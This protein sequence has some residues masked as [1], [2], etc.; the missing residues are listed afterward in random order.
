MK[1]AHTLITFIGTGR[2]EIARYCDPDESDAVHQTEYMCQ[3]LAKLADVDH[4]VLLGTE[5]AFCKHLSAINRALGEIGKPD[6]T[7]VKIPS[8][9]TAE[10]AWKIFTIVWRQLSAVAEQ[11][12]ILDITHGFRSQGF[13]AGAVAAFFR[14][15]NPEKKQPRLV[16]GGFEM[17]EG[18]GRRGSIQPAPI[19]DLT[20]FIDFVAWAEAILLF[21][22]TGRAGP[23]A[24]LAAAPAETL[25]F[26]KE[27]AALRD[28]LARLGCALHA[29][30]PDFETIRTGALLRGD[31]ATAPRL[32]QAVEVA[33]SAAQGREELLE[34]LI[35]ALGRVRDFVTPLVDPTPTAPTTLAGPQARQVL[36]GLARAY[37]RTGRY[38]EALT[39]VREG[40]VSL[41]AADAAGKPGAEFDR[42]ERG[43]AEDRLSL[44]IRR[45]TGGDTAE[46][47]MLNDLPKCRNDINHGG[48]NKEPA[49]GAD[50]V[51]ATEDM[52]ALLERPDLAGRMV[53]AAARAPERPLFLNLSNHPHSDWP[54]T[55][56]QAARALAGGGEIRD[57][58]FPD[59]PSD[60]ADV[61]ALVK[62]AEKDIETLEKTGTVMCAMVQGE[63]TTTY[64]LVGALR[65]RGIRC[66]AAVP[67]ARD[68]PFTFAGFR[69][70]D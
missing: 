39:T 41:L 49:A 43:K 45:G 36:A 27:D 70:Y 28:S 17:Q 58:A 65:R 15:T 21:Q 33:M 38:P 32:V 61:K 67:A 56:R 11:D 50:L 55:Q 26:L 62:G 24:D 6:A 30:G 57:M 53:A 52:V 44:T 19:V 23:L 22:H 18:K 31:Q 14:L 3:A 9:G 68:E 2:Y 54:E 7:D 60:G 16:Y 20:S 13:L 48:F 4:V 25:P 12:S 5:A 47:R 42:T 8:C 46:R 34:P 63:Y 69:V 1:K 10:E 37:H 66:V 51:A 40:F 64:A 35:H 29:F 59:V